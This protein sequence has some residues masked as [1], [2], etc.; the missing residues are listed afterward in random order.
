M[1]LTLQINFKELSNGD[2]SF[3]TGPIW[4][5]ASWDVSD[6]MGQKC[7]KRTDVVYYEKKTEEEL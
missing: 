6:L 2:G 3:W 1:I 7:P 4:P 5:G